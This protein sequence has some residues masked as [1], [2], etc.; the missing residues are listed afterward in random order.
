MTDDEKV[1]SVLTEEQAQN[2]VEPRIS[3]AA[4]WYWKQTYFWE[5]TAFIFRISILVMSTLVT[6]I[7]AYPGSADPADAQRMKWCVVIISAITTLLS[8]LLTKTGIE[9]TAK[10]RERGR[11]EIVAL[12]QKAMLRLTKRM[13][14][15]V[16][17]WNLF[18]NVR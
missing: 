16:R 11:I 15:G 10:L 7:A 14:T 6:I 12:E 3:G 17:A 9:A 18:R 5:Q 2:E 1:K 8:A 4:G 13:M